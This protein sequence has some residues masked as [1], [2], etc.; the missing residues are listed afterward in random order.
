MQ[1]DSTNNNNNNDQTNNKI[2]LEDES[3]KSPTTKHIKSKNFLSNISYVAISKEHFNK[4]NF[5][6][7]EYSLITNSLNPFSLKRKAEQPK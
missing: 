2:T 4:E 7:D 6:F 5:V 1:G 3:A